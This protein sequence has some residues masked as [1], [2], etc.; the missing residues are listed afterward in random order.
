M[1][2]AS[3]CPARK[4][5]AADD[6]TRA[7]APSAPLRLWR[8]AA[9]KTAL[10]R[11]GWPQRSART[12]ER[13]KENQHRLVSIF[14]CQRRLRIIV[15]DHMWRWLRDRRF[16]GCKFCRQHPLG[17]DYLDFFCEEAELHVELDGRQHGFPDQRQ[18]DA[19]RESLAKTRLTSSSP[20]SLQSAVGPHP[21]AEI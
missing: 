20:G 3:E 16:S 9:P 5:K 13:I 18:H 4:K 8:L 11:R 1:V 12:N 14:N 2:K 17:D 10:R 15:I 21:P 19:E 6:P 7:P